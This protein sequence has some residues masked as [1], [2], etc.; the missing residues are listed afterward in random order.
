VRNR[1]NIE[2]IR[3][4][5]Y[6]QICGSRKALEVHHIKTRGAGG[7]DEPEN[8]VLLCHYHHRLVQDHLLDLD[9]VELLSGPVPDYEELIQRAIDCVQA[10]D[11]NK[12]TLGAII[13]LLVNI[14]QAPRGEIA[15]QLA[16]STRY[17]SELMKVWETFPSEA[18]RIPELS[19]QHH[20]I[21][22]RT[23]DPYKWL[24]KAAENGWS[25]REF[26]LAIK[27]PCPEEEV[28]MERA[29]RARNQVV[30]VLEAGGEPAEWLKSELAQ[31]VG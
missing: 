12:W 26:E 10:G 25:A 30:R 19:W 23:N 11:E 27:S 28:A 21:A 6:C 18:Q 29:K 8:L 22:A 13:A 3:E 7:S 15:N 16:C 20:R 5:G 2:K 14:E 24:E 9:S 4:I 31:L 17:V 1:E